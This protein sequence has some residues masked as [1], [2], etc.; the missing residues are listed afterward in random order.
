MSHQS[1]NNSQGVFLRDWR[2]SLLI[3]NTIPL[4][5]TFGN[6][7]GFIPFDITFRVSLGLEDP[8][9]ANSF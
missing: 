3:V 6:Q 9:T 5:E 2:E 7:P 1:H 8:L 4:S